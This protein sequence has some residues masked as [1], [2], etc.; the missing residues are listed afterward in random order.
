MTKVWCA[1]IEC[2]HNKNNQ[3]KAKE[4]NLSNGNVHTVHQG[5]LHICKCK[6]FEMSED[7][8]RMSKELEKH[9]GSMDRNANADHCI[10]CG[11]IIPE[12]NIVC[13]NC[14]VD[15]EGKNG[16]R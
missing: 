3:C 12:G 8:K 7:V 6:A 16:K 11:A 1:A 10:C 9:F 5:L 2:E 4:I 15:V 14:L 13:S